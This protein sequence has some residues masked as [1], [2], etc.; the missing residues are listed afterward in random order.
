MFLSNQLMRYTRAWSHEGVSLLPEDKVYVLADEHGNTRPHMLNG[1]TATPLFQHAGASSWHEWDAA[2]FLLIGDH[3]PYFLGVF[4]VG[5][6][7]SIAMLSWYQIRKPAHRDYGY[8]SQREKAAVR[9]SES[10]HWLV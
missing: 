2:L 10:E 7:G 6:I 8:V 9:S 1:H 3:Y 5:V 4:V